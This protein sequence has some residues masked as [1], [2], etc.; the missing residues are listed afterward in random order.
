MTNRFAKIDLHELIHNIPNM[1]VCLSAL[2]TWECK[3][4]WPTFH[5]KIMESYT[6]STEVFEKGENAKLLLVLS[7][8]TI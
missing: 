3:V 1:S 8:G 2:V 7:P 6:V 5:H 4:S